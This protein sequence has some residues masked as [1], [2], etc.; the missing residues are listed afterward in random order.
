MC[1]PSH[2]AFGPC[3]QSCF[4]SVTNWRQLS[5]I[6][7]LIVGSFLRLI[8][9]MVS[10][11]QS[12]SAAA[13]SICIRIGILDT[14]VEQIVGPMVLINVLILVLILNFRLNV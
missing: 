11:R 13:A 12:S 4:N 3:H 14:G 1:L 7:V 10:R 8:D 5:E 2:A 6:L 9:F